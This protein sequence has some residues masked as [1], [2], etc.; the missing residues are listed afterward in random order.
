MLAND[1]NTSGAISRLHVLSKNK[2]PA[3]LA[4]F[5]HGLEMLGFVSDWADIPMF[6]GA[7]SGADVTPAVAARVD[8][9]L[10]QRAAARAAKDWGNADEVRDIL[11]AAGVQVTDIGGQATWEPGPDFDAT[12]LGDL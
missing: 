3:T 1:L 2:T 7:E 8:A 10:N 11:N 9:L 12:K 6:D 5:A 4:G